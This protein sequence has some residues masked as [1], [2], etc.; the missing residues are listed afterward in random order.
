MKRKNKRSKEPSSVLVIYGDGS[1]GSVSR[2]RAGRPEDE[3]DRDRPRRASGP[4]RYDRIWGCVGVS[5]GA[6]GLGKRR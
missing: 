2:N 6:P 3:L 4:S 1:L 5:G